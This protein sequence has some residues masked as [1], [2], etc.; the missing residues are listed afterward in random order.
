VRLLPPQ[1]EGV[2]FDNN[3]CVLTSSMS[4]FILSM[5]C[6]VKQRVSHY[7]VANVR[8]FNE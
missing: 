6:I 4:F 1:G 5:I 8:M 7:V 3:I 2:I